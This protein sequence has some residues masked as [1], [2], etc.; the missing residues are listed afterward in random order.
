MEFE[1]H[2]KVWTLAS[3]S[4]NKHTYSSQKVSKLASQPTCCCGGARILI[5]SPTS[6]NKARLSVATH[7]LRARPY[8]G[9][10]PAGCEK[11]NAGGGHEGA[12]SKAPTRRRRS[13]NS[14]CNSRQRCVY[15]VYVFRWCCTILLWSLQA[16][17][18][19]K[20]AEGD[21]KGQPKHNIATCSR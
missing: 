17:L 1:S 4:T 21:Q 12:T 5:E 13:R 18:L 9:S 2:S 7:T 3:V 16:F 19:V 8:L 15:C 6:Y 14:H 10:L 20:L 11:A